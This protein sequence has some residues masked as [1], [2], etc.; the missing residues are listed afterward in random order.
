M[1]PK[2][3]PKATTPIK[4]F[5]GSSMTHEEI[6][7]VQYMVTKLELSCHRRKSKSKEILNT[8]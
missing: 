4:P 5:K 1:P 2:K 6:G 8:R 7:D 3:D